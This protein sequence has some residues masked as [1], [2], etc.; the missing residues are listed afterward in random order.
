[1]SIYGGSLLNGLTVSS[2]GGGFFGHDPFWGIFGLFLDRAWGLFIFA[3][4]YFVFIPGVPFARNRK[5]IGRWWVF[6]PLCIVLYVLLVGMFGKW[7]GDVSPVPRQLVPILPLLVICAGLTCDRL[8][9]LA[10]KVI[11]LFFL[12]GQVVLTVFALIY[13][14]TV[15]AIHGGLNALIPKIL[16]SNRLSNLIVR[17]FPLLHPATAKSIVLLIAWLAVLTVFSILLRKYWMDPVYGKLEYHE[18][19]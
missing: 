18:K 7:S 14:R 19:T 3:P 12:A 2:G 6:I 4:V 5:D 8:K 15:F 10:A 11:L 16:G 9:S 13:P 1:H 17:L